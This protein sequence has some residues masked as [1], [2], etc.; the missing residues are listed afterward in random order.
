MVRVA[1]SAASEPFYNQGRHCRDV[2]P[3]S[4]SQLVRSLQFHAKVESRL[5]AAGGKRH[6]KAFGPS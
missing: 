6:A 5:Q 3:C 2:Q 1:A 4:C